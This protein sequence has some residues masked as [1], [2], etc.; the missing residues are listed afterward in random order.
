MSDPDPF[1]Q[2]WEER[3]ALPGYL[4]GAAPNRFLAAQLHRLRP[5]MRA[6]AVADGDGRNGVWLAE[7]GLRVHSVDR[8]ALA[9]EKAQALARSRGVSLEAEVADL[10]QWRWPVD[11]CDV[12]V[13]VFFHL[14]SPRREAMHARMV[15]ALRPGG[16]L[17]LEAFSKAQLDFASGGPQDEAA[18]YSAAELRNDFAALERLQVEE[19]ETEL[20]EGLYHQGR[21]ALVR[22]MGQKPA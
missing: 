4:Y 5:G 1:R 10:F 12:V 20:D 17:I 8:S 19:L 7:Q 15:R 14:A 16:W 6:L 22:L 3:Y 21:A 9:V 18:L 13:S 2:T 11:V